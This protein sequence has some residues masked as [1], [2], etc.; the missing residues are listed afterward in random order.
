MFINNVSCYK[1][2]KLGNSENSNNTHSQ[3]IYKNLNKHVAQTTNEPILD[4]FGSIT[5]EIPTANNKPQFAM[6][7]D[8][9]KY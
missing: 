6:F 8:S 3:N 7:A 9:Y 4:P 2:V 1:Y 5:V